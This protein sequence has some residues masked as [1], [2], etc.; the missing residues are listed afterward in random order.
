MTFLEQ[1]ELLRQKKPHIALQCVNNENSPYCQY[2]EESKNCYMTFGSQG[3][4]DCFYNHRVIYCTDCNDCALCQNCELCYECVDCTKCYNCNYCIRSEDCIDSDF[5][6]YSRGLQNCFGCVGL[7]KQQYCIFNQ[8]YSKEEYEKLRAEWKNVPP[9]EIYKHMERL[10]LE[11]PRVAMYG[12]NNEESYGENLNNCKNTFWGFDSFGL[13]DC[14]YVY[15]CHDSKNLLDCSNIGP[16]EQCYENM[17]G[18]DLNN[19]MYCF[20]C[21]FSS[22]LEYCEL[23]YNSKNCF[24]CVGLNHGEYCILNQ[25]YSKEEYF[26]KV[27]EIKAEMK[28]EGSYGKWFS[29]TYPEVITY[30]L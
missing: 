14:T 4:R 9:A 1:F 23:V 10:I 7:R 11:T 26:K 20:G 13:H 30:G 2:T 16:A 8:K 18:G 22:E 17:N 21:W 6:V 29:S 24:M 28:R 19:C 27:A 25:K 15:N 12:K 5:C 3:C